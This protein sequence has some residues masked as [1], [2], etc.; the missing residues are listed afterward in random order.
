MDCTLCAYELYLMEYGELLNGP[1]AERR[2]PILPTPVYL[3]FHTSL[4]TSLSQLGFAHG[5]EG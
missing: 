5:P 3:L 2:D 4:P 1:G